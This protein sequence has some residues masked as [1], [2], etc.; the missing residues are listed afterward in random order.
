MSKG[1]DMTRGLRGAVLALALVY[2]GG[3]S[4]LGMRGSA[5]SGAASAKKGGYYLDDGPGDNPP[6]N[7]DAIPN[8]V[9]K[10]EPLARGANRPY[11]ALGKEF[12]PDTADRPYK[13]RGMASWYGRRYHGKQTSSGEVYDMYAMTAA[14]PTLPI[15][16]YVRVTNL[17]NGRSVIVRVNDRGPFVDNRLIDLSYTAAYKLDILRGVTQ[18]EVERLFPEDTSSA[19]VQVVRVEEPLIE[20]VKRLEPAALPSIEPAKPSKAVELPRA[21]EPRKVAGPASYLQVGAFASSTTADGLVARIGEL[22][23]AAAQRVEIGGLFKVHV[24]PFRDAESL[25]RTAARIQDIFGIRPLK[26]PGGRAAGS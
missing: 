25:E 4:M 11:V 21:A 26:V 13:V 20:E 17:N 6:A 24:G 18:V 7:L 14:H 16:S 3:C 9:P 8:A 15:P 10:A 19:V 1:F 5:P 22:L 12:V 23:G 2:L